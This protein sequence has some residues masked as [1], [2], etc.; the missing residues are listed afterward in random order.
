M[1]KVPDTAE[2]YVESRVQLAYLYDKQKKY[3]QAESTLKQALA[4]KPK[5]A[6]LMS[7]LAGV[8]R[9]KKDLPAAIA[10]LNDMIVLGSEKRQ[11]SFYARRA[12]R[13]GQAQAGEY[14]RD[15]PGD[16]A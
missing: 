13:R 4:K 15:A 2:H 7:F 16:R 10:L 9:E 14:R 6:E 12:L 11:V 8:Y 5:D 3:D 1:L